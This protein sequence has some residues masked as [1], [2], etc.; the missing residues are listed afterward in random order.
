MKSN[1]LRTGFIILFLI[2]VI[3]FNIFYGSTIQPNYTSKNVQEGELY[4][5]SE[6]KTYW[7]EITN[8]CCQDG[9]LYVLYERKAIMQIFRPDGNYSSSY[10]YYDTNGRGTLGIDDEYA[11]LEDRNNNWYKFKDGELIEEIPFSDYQS[12]NEVGNSLYADSL[13][14]KVADNGYYYMRWASVFFHNDESGADRCI[15]R[16][17]FFFVIYEWAWL[18]LIS[19]ACLIGASLLLIISLAT[20]KRERGQK[21]SEQWKDGTRVLKQRALEQLSDHSREGT[22]NTPIVLR[23]GGDTFS[24]LSIPLAIMLIGAVIFSVAWHDIIPVL[25]IS[26]AFFVIMTIRMIMVYY[27]TIVIDETGVTVRFM[28]LQ[29]TYRWEK[30]K[31]KRYVDYSFIDRQPGFEKK[32]GYRLESQDYE[33]GA[34]FLPKKMRKR[35]DMYP[36]L[37]CEIYHPWSC[38]FVNFAN[39]NLSD[40]ELKKKDLDGYVVDE[41]EFLARLAGWNVFLDG[42][43][44]KPL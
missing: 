11:Y 12:Y 7:T 25:I 34:L 10:A 18:M 37:Y 22:K 2:A 20:E 35:I 43:G 40:K 29:K 15:I 1:K 28:T 41:K 33:A 23:P 36:E 21:E 5:F 31:T 39:T 17:P 27:R 19:F 38:V 24:R 26:L 32:N 4:H 8:Y 30:I 16:R 9:Y 14:T 42:P 3:S 13:E 44:E 6:K